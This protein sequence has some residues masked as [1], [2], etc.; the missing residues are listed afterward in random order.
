MALFLASW[1]TQK[2]RYSTTWGISKAFINFVAIKVKCALCNVQFR[3]RIK[4]TD[5]TS[6]KNGQRIRWTTCIISD[7]QR[8]TSLFIERRVL[9]LVCRMV[10]HF[11]TTRWSCLVDAFNP[12]LS[13]LPQ[14]ACLARVCVYHSGWG[15]MSRVVPCFVVKLHDMSDG[16]A[17]GQ[18]L[19]S[20]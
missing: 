1:C 12:G 15:P 18:G 14:W 5:H 17:L 13:V 8:V 20:G 3:H 9:P 7:V 11:T 6:K 19:D 10:I 16:E 4:Q 2:P